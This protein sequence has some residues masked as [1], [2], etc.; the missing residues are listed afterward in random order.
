MVFLKKIF[1]LTLLFNSS[2]LFS[3]KDSIINYYNTKKVIVFD[4]NKAYTFEILT[5]KNDS[6][7]LSRIFRR[8]GTLKNYQHYKS[9]EKK[10]KVGEFVVYGINQKVI[11][12]VNHNKDGLKHGKY[13]SWFNNGNL[14]TEGNFYN[15]KKEGL[16]KIYHT[17]KVLAGKGIFLKDSLIRENYYSDNGELTPLE[18]VICK[19]KPNF[20][21]G[22]KAYFKK[23]KS[24]NKT[25]GYNIKG[26]IYVTYVIDENGNINEVYIDEDIPEKLNKYIVSFFKSL[27][28]WSPYI[29]R[30]RKVPY[31]YTQKLSFK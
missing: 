15:G 3:Q 10:I 23:L 12:L 17:N 16:F 27:K 31:Y 18:D 21:G 24:L 28:G 25:L 5:K 30:N 4:K 8:N 13:K 26:D 22:K 14:N 7:W 1:I 20:K 11:R 2:F 29:D 19:Q 9:S 6:L